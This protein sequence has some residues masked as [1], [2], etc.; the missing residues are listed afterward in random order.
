MEPKDNA[1]AQNTK[2][3]ESQDQAKEHV[4]WFAGGNQAGRNGVKSQHP[5]WHAGKHHTAMNQYDM[6]D[7]TG[8]NEQQ[9]NQP[10]GPGHRRILSHV[11]PKAMNLHVGESRANS[12]GFPPFA[13]GRDSFAES[14]GGAGVVQVFQRV[15]PLEGQINLSSG[16]YIAPSSS[17]VQVT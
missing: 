7:P 13:R 9:V 14:H 2:S 11:G 5:A 16:S 10:G 12:Q 6:A 1:I 3:I 15:T 17:G 4:D 8:L